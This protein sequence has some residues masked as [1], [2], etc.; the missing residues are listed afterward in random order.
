M[1]YRYEISDERAIPCEKTKGG[2]TCECQEQA[3][4]FHTLIIDCIGLVGLLYFKLL[5]GFAL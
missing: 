3:C 2:E 4:I 5:P 1:K